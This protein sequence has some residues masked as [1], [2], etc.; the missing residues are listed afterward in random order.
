MDDNYHW[1]EQ[2]IKYADESNDDRLRMA[3]VLVNNN[4]L[5]AFACN[6]KN[7]S[8]SKDLI[9]QLK[10]KNINN[11]EK[12]FLTINTFD[13]NEF[14]LNELL[15]NINI[16]KI[17]LGLPDPRLNIY[18]KDDPIIHCKNIYRFKESLQEEIYKQNYNYYK[19]SKQNIENNKY[20]YS[21]RVSSFVKEKLNNAGINIEAE[22]ISQRKQT[23]LLSSYISKKYNIPQERSYELIT[24]IL[25][26]AFD[27][28]YSEYDYSNDI[29][30]INPDWSKDFNDIYK[31][32]NSKSIN[33]INILNVG[34]GGGIEATKLFLNCKN[35]TFVDIAHNGLEKLKTLIPTSKIVNSRAEDLSMLEDN[36]YELYVSLRTYNS[37]FFN[38][39]QAVKEAYRVLKNDS[40]AIISISNGFL[41]SKEKRIIPGIIIPK[42]D[43]V[44]LYRG[45]DI[46]RELQETLT[47]YNF[48]EIEFIPTN[49]EL[50]ITARVNK[51]E[52]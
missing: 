29:R 45:L 44:D 39:T 27:H 38:I 2:A 43:F 20:F 14:Q 47:N 7:I 30:S 6:N 5:V 37:S 8:W 24:N 25:A 46:V 1:M 3:A 21:N 12:L 50:Y 32:T 22:E 17:Y 18:L 35:V 28:K 48:K 51:D 49:G 23:T 33:E 15:K 41:D 13:N 40:V 34:V 26:E 16:K 36:S 9:N 42:I 19:S 4:E 11:I 10:D 52:F 31:K